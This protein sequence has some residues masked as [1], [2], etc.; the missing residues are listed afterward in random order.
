MKLFKY[1]EKEATCYCTCVLYAQNEFTS[2]VEHMFSLW[3]C[4][5]FYYD[6]L[7]FS[8]GRIGRWVYLWLAT[9]IHTPPSHHAMQNLDEFELAPEW[10]V[11]WCGAWS[12]TIND[13]IIMFVT[14]VGY[15]LIQLCLCFYILSMLKCFI[16]N[17]W[18]HGKCRMN[19]TMQ[20][21]LHRE[22]EIFP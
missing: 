2:F 1:G 10:Q 6:W 11:W 21:L 8:I 3:G 5:M 16:S 14:L 12:C 9:L 15:V 17:N 18:L 4:Y 13:D 7:C 19:A 22:M 20:Q